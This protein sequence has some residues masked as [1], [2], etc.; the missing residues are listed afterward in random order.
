KADIIAQ[1]FLGQKLGCARCHDAPFHP[2]KQKDLF[3]LAAM[4]NGKPLKLP[5]A[6]SVPSRHAL[7]SLVVSPE[8]ERFAQVIV[9]RVWK[10]YMGLGLVEPADDWSQAAAS[11]PELMRYL[12]RELA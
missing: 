6:S 5:G 1:A 8:N 4:M 2:F 3:S 10:R 12:A 11:H 9:N 7:A